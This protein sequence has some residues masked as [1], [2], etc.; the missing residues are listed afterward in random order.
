VDEVHVHGTLC[1][2]ALMKRQRRPL[3]EN[4][5]AFF[6]TL[7]RVCLAPVSTMDNLTENESFENP[8]LAA[9]CALLLDNPAVAPADF[10]LHNQNPN[11][12]PSTC[13]ASPSNNFATN[14]ATLSRKGARISKESIRVLKNWLT[15]H[16]DRPYPRSDDLQFLQQQTGLERKQITNW[17]A[18]ARRRGLLRDSGQNYPQIQTAQTNPRDIIARPGTPAVQLGLQHKDPLQR[19][20][21]SP[22]ETEAASFGDIYRAVTTG[23]DRSN[24]M[25]RL[26]AC[27]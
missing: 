20:V 16:E 5:P 22:P 10:Q 8:G 9:L 4:L 6:Y 19:W 26:K 21:E 18:N 24:G 23:S 2:L 27:T 7:H 17:F 12:Y 11:S 25:S 14:Y 13:S 3:A 15:T 1:A